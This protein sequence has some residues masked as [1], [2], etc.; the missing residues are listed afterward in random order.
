MFQR[1]ASTTD[2]TIAAAFLTAILAGNSAH[3]QQAGGDQPPFQQN[4]SPAAPSAAP[5]VRLPVFEQF[6][7][8]QLAK[9]GRQI[10]KENFKE[11]FQDLDTLKS[12]PDI[13]YPLPDGRRYVSSLAKINDFIG[14][15]KPDSLKF[16]R[17]IYDPKAEQLY[18]QAMTSPAAAAALLQT[19]ADDYPHT[20]WGPK[21][22]LA[23]SA[24]YMDRGRFAQAQRCLKQALKLIPDD[25]STPTIL[26]KLAAAAHLAGDSAASRSVFNALEKKYPQA[27]AE[28]GGRQQKLTDFVAEILSRPATQVQPEST[29]GIAIMDD[30]PDLVLKP[31]WRFPA[32]DP[33]K[34]FAEQ[35]C[36]DLARLNK[37]ENTDIKLV[38]GN[39]VLGSDKIEGKDVSFNAAAMIHP[40]VVDKTVY[41]R[42][43][44]AVRAV[45]LLTGQQ[46]WQSSGCTLRKSDLIPALQRDSDLGRL[47][48]TAG[49]GMIFTLCDFNIENTGR[50]MGPPPD[51]NQGTSCLAALSMSE[52]GKQV[53]KVG[54]GRGSEDIIRSGRFLC[55]PTY[56]DGRLYIVSRYRDYYYL[57]CIQA[58]TGE[59][60]WKTQ[61]SIPAPKA[62]NFTPS[63]PDIGTPPAVADGL[64]VLATNNYV[65]A[66]VDALTGRHVWAYQYGPPDGE[67]NSRQQ[68]RI[69][70]MGNP[71]VVAKG[72]VICLPADAQSVLAMNLDDGRPLWT[73]ENKV[74][75]AGFAELSAIDADRFLLSGGSKLAVFKATDGEKLGE[76]TAPAGE[77]Q[78]PICG[79]PAIGRKSVL[80]SGEGVLYRMNLSDYSV[81][82]VG[83]IGPAG[84]LGN[85]VAVDGMLVA[86]NA[87]GMYAY[88]SKAVQKK[89]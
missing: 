66:A 59:L 9:I 15:L 13:F 40:I 75:R 50:R 11:A 26:A 43:E 18:K 83:K 81:S 16:Y 4:S 47:A 12:S 35:I 23:L 77:L 1:P 65:I 72:K 63:G 78:W 84:L 58:E 68:P 38:G 71:I 7:D 20:S 80:V 34:P 25:P 21:A 2:W 82:T 88:D 53:W 64:V 5:Q 55:A 51:A 60:V 48:I 85:L 73:G 42:N 32:D 54:N 19:V 28:M 27:Q 39:V 70:K 36:I 14:G 17:T 46:K 74:P 30:C 62:N 61:I 33:Q 67:D 52:M 10:D 41:F 76:W 49:G 8:E 24:I 89:P 57:L 69:Y 56:C 37:V 3:A 6:L 87:A 22:L 31:V 44:K 86:A 29:A 45:D 79:R